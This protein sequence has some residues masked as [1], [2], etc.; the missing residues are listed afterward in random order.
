M[1][2][3]QEFFPLLSE[4]LRR[5]D[6]SYFF[7]WATTKNYQWIGFWPTFNMS[8]QKNR[9]ISSWKIINLFP[10]TTNSS[11]KIA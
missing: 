9:G 1:I 2:Y 4:I 6:S 5:F 3:F 8:Q 11:L 10:S 7:L